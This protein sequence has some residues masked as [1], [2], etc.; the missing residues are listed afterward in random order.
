MA[1]MAEWSAA[2]RRGQTVLYRREVSRPRGR[3]V[4]VRPAREASAAFA[5]ARSPEEVVVA[6]VVREQVVA[7]FFPAEALASS[8]ESIR[9]LAV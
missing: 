4:S 8:Q 5:L 7:A 9:V 6:P 1:R 2:E 3:R